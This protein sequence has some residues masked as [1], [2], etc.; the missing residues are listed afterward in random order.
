MYNLNPDAFYTQA[1]IAFPRYANDNPWFAWQYK[2]SVFDMQTPVH[3]IFAS[4]AAYEKVDANKSKITLLG[5]T[6][7]RTD[8]DLVRSFGLS[9]AKGVQEEECRALIVKLTNERRVAVGLVPINTDPKVNQH[10][11]DDKGK[12][13]IPVEGAGGI[14]STKKW[15]PMLNDSF[16]ISGAHHEHV[17]YLALVDDEATSW[18]G[19]SAVAD[20][21]ERWRSFFV[22]NLGML[23]S[24][25][26]AGSF[27]RV[28]TRELIGLLSFGYKPDFDK[29]QLAFKI[30]DKKASDGAT[31]SDYLT[32]LAN[33]DFNRQGKA[34]CLK[35]IS[36][37]LFGKE[38]AL[39]PGKAD[40][41]LGALA[42]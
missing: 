21:T 2:G 7:L 18:E 17:F 8:E 5:D 31:H 4:N 13:I 24:D 9:S 33:L 29:N 22:K 35:A 26:S 20:L 38:E 11:P 14:L 32:A 30:V 36:T 15:S 16:I 10:L 40:V 1:F 34:K 27:P 28:L 25:S 12:K 39:D 41:A 23:W 37:F 19:L 6:K 42:K 3:Y